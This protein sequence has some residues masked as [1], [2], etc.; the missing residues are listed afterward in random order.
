MIPSCRRCTLSAVYPLIIV[1]VLVRTQNITTDGEGHIDDRAGLFGQNF[2]F[3]QQGFNVALGGIVSRERIALCQF[4]AFGLCCTAVGKA[5][6]LVAPSAIDLPISDGFA[7]IGVDATRLH[8]SSN[9]H[10]ASP[11]AFLSRTMISHAALDKTRVGLLRAARLDALPRRGDQNLSALLGP[12]RASLSAHGAERR[13]GIWLEP[14]DRALRGRGRAGVFGAQVEQGRGLRS[15]W[16][17]GSL[18][19]ELK[20]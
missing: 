19:Y 16:L 7:T 10:W 20:K 4:V 2:Q 14:R 8:V 6:R 11:G 5:E 3:V 1:S 18:H 13:G 15:G 12:R 9:V 17:N